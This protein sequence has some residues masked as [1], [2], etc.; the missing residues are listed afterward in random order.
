MAPVKQALADAGVDP[1]KID[2]VVLVGGSTRIPKVQ[3]LV[4]DFFGK[5]PHKGVNPDEVVAVG[6]AIQ[7]GVLAGEVKDLLLL[8]VTPLSLG[9]ETMGGAVA[10]IIQ[11]NS[12]I[13]CHATEGFTTYADNQTGIDFNI[14]QGE[15][16]MAKDCR[17]LGRFQLKGIPPMP[18]GMARVAVR[19]HI[20]AD[21]V[22]TVAAKEEKSGQSARIEVQPMHCLT[23]GEVESMLQESIEHAREDFAGR[24]V[25]ELRT[26][27]GIMV[28]ATEKN[29]PAGRRGLD[30]ETLEDLEAALERAKAAAAG[31]DAQALQAAR[32]EL[33]HATLPLA[34]LLMDSVAKRALAGKTLDEV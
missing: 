13:P 20:D 4:R 22:L 1:K 26:E 29:L 32:D 6:A 21:G 30:R 7:A 34:A 27:I 23:D 31:E 25:A 28:R 17:S 2:E 3:Q 10:K 11:R 16:E 5:E 9:I 15:R 14:V 24:R 33:E 18:A 8:D 12:T 19:F